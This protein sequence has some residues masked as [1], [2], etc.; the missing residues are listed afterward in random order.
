MNCIN[1]V[2]KVV[3]KFSYGLCGYVLA[4]GRSFNDED[5]FGDYDVVIQVDLAKGAEK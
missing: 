4:M 1:K 3:V 2:L 5:L